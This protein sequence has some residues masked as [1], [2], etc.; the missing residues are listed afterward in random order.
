MSKK[1]I[2]TKLIR[3]FGFGY[4]DQ[5]VVVNKKDDQTYVEDFE[6]LE[7][8][9]R[10]LPILEKKAKDINDLKELEENIEEPEDLEDQDLDHEEENNETK[11]KKQLDQVY[12][13]IRD[14][15]S[16]QIYQ[17]QGKVSEDMKPR[18]IVDLFPQASIVLLLPGI[19]IYT[20]VLLWSFGL[21]EMG[22][23]ET[24]ISVFLFSTLFYQGYHVYNS[25]ISTLDLAYKGQISGHDMYV[26]KRTKYLRIWSQDDK[27]LV[28][29]SIGLM[30]SFI[31]PIMAEN[32]ALNS[33]NNNM[34][35]RVQKGIK[36]GE[37][38][39]IGAMEKS[40]VPSWLWLLG[41]FLAGILVGYLLA[42]GVQP[43]PSPD[44]STIIG[45]MIRWITTL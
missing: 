45:V 16:D 32:K 37:R 24:I 35:D 4:P 5:V 6:I 21:I 17:V 44:Q 36:I 19:I 11:T 18:A 33:E 38:K 43:A 30:I 41:L 28:E 2:L 34:E 25:Y 7:K 40:Q 39:V 22:Y 26:P 20:M 9:S 10:K 27:N 13:M 8:S 31:R 42:G 12:S 15:K 3:A 14:K 1:E 29:K 23:P